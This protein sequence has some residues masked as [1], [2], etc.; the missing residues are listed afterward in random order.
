MSAFYTLL[1]EKIVSI[2]RYD[3]VKVIVYKSFSVL[4]LLVLALCCNLK[5]C[6]FM[7]QKYRI[8]A[9]ASPSRFEANVGLFRSLMKGI[10][11]PYVL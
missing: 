7:I 6:K 11:D 2:C 3:A 9:S 10:F 8:V 4:T 5:K 1:K